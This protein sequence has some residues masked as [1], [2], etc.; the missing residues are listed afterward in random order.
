MPS[1]TDFDALVGHNHRASRMAQIKKVPLEAPLSEEGKQAKTKIPPKASVRFAIPPKQPWLL[2]NESK[3]VS[4]R[5]EE[6]PADSKNELTAEDLVTDES[7][8]IDSEDEAVLAELEAQEPDIEDEYLVEDYLQQYEQQP[9]II[10]SAAEGDVKEL[11]R[12]EK[13]HSL[14]L[15]DIE[16]AKIHE[17]Y[18]RRTKAEKQFRQAQFSWE[19]EVECEAFAR[20]L[21]R[22]TDFYRNRTRNEDSDDE[23]E[24]EEKARNEDGVLELRMHRFNEL[25]CVKV[26][27]AHPSHHKSDQDWR[28]TLPPSFHDMEQS[29]WERKIQWECGVTTEDADN[30][31]KDVHKKEQ[32]IAE[33]AE[34]LLNRVYNHELE[35]MDFSV[36]VNW[37][38]ADA[39]QGYNEALARSVPLVLQERV[40]GISVARLAVPP[41]RPTPLS[42]SDVYMQ[43]M[44]RELKGT[45]GSG[46]QGN[47]AKE[48]DLE[49]FIAQ[50]QKKRER[51]AIDKTKRVLEAMGT[52]DI[53][54][55]QGRT[56]TSSLMGPGGTERTGRPTKGVGSSSLAYDAEQVDH[57]DLIFNHHLV[58]PDFKRAELRHYHR[59]RIPRSLVRTDRVWQLQVRADSLTTSKS[60]KSS[61]DGSTVIGSNAMVGTHPGAISQTRLKNEA[62]L[63]PAEGDL[64]IFEYCEERPPLF[65]GKGFA[66]KIVN[67]YRGDKKK[68]P[69]SVGGGDRPPK[70]KR[71]GEK[72]IV[73]S[74]KAEKPKLEGPT[75]YDLDNITD[76][77][78][79]KKLKKKSEINADGEG[80]K[81]KKKEHTVEILP[82]GVTEILLPKVHGPFIGEVDEGTTQSGL[83]ANLFVAPIFRHSPEPSDF[84]LILG[85][86]PRSSAAGTQTMG[87]TIRPFPA[88]VFCCGQT[89]P[90][91][92]VYAPNTTGEKNI[93]AP[94][95]TF[96]IAKYLTRTE[97]KEGQGLRFDE[98]TDR[99]FTNTRI[100]QNALRQRIKQVA[101][102]DKNTQIWTSKRIGFEEYPGVEALGRRFSPES[103][104]SYESACA[105]VQRLADLG[106]VDI[107]N[108]NSVQVVGQALMYLNGAVSA[109]RE[110]KSKMRKMAEN[111]KSLDKSKKKSGT[112][113]VALYEEAAN[114]LEAKWKEARQKQ[115]I[116]RF[117]YAELVLAPWHLTQEFIEVHKNAQGSGMMKLSGIGDPS[118]RLE[119]YNFMREADTKPSKHVGNTDGA[120]NAQIKKITGT[121]NDLRKLTMKEM[122]SLLRSYGMQDKQIATLK[123]WDRVHCIRDLSTKAASDGMGDGMERYARGE[124]L[125]LADQKQM[126]RDRIQEIWRRQRSA[127]STDAGTF[128]ADKKAAASAAQAAAAA[129]SAEKPP[130]EAEV[131]QPSQVD[132]D[133]DSDS[134]DDDDLVDM[135]EEGMMDGR[136]ANRII[137]DQLRGDSE[138]PVNALQSDTG[139]LRDDA[140]D[141]AAFLRQKEEERN[142]S[143]GL[144]AKREVDQFVRMR[145][146]KGRKCVRRRIT[147]THPDGTQVVTFQFV[148]DPMEV[149]KV[150]QKKKQQDTDGKIITTKKGAKGRAKKDKIKP[151]LKTKSD[152]VSDVLLITHAMF[153]EDAEDISKPNLKLKFSTKSSKKQSGPKSL[154]GKMGSKK[155]KSP[156][157][158][159]ERDKVEKKKKKRKRE[160]DEAD[161]YSAAPHRRGASSR[162]E[163]GSI[164]ERKPH[165]MLAD[166]LESI[167]E[168]VEGRPHSGAFRRPVSRR[169]YPNY[170]ELISD[171][172]DLQTIRDKNKRYEYKKADAFVEDFALMRNNAIKFNGKNS[173]L[174]N[175]ATAIYNFVKSTIESNREELL[176]LEEAVHQQKMNSGRKGLKRAK[177]SGSPSPSQASGLEGTETA[178]HNS[179]NVTSLILDGVETTVNLGNIDL[180]FDGSDSEDSTSAALKI[181]A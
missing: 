157:K 121:E 74:S 129:A 175:E 30:A 68:C 168:Q 125:K 101:V 80:S 11:N 145:D 84:L 5:L 118:G 50:K 53:G 143:Q 111:A 35:T 65:M 67:Y 148:V 31:A 86:K 83:I 92:R 132:N 98:I 75:E 141:L 153:E 19:M 12:Q 23:E 72:N 106:I 117:I 135:L 159:K 180:S 78:G 115:E 147:K 8:S 136:E 172:I 93:L 48:E 17:E 76:L 60:Q 155:Q 88:S 131:E 124:K 33:T 156:G 69:I 95:Q 26:P 104:Q 79:A 122:A 108:G 113:Q 165:V 127:L 20:R 62:D 45:K 41:T 119:G 144:V 38:G 169:A 3:I 100:L 25:S 152:Y 27:G 70:L 142:A 126:Y 59:P 105:C 94:F 15:S 170:Y 58:K 112:S 4:F 154:L 140:R 109:A 87:V 16:Q 44:E 61:T 160:E 49:Y 161:L 162:R 52:M 37:D 139:A 137:A 40:A 120:L 96:Q 82:E 14:L 114:Q 128:D 2:L 13:W 46:G 1:S 177:T 133:L 28:K 39:P 43:R 51:M 99:L 34:A 164:R 42:Q 81:A 158:V 103:V 90:R 179:N 130:V 181:A 89:E 166:R 85:K 55:G 176:S 29:N 178:S 97:T 151:G 174:G 18:T 146:M 36:T 167:R 107:Y 63:T 116:A 7:G 73:T 32:T 57:L 24:E 47:N 22:R 54:G 71:H 56:I 77:I 171:P 150:I 173:D 138:G 91:V 110:R 134:D 66:C 9:A 21:I 10:Q 102:Y 163:R 6:Y 123:R 64:V 149:E